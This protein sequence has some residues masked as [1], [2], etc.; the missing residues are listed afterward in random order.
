MRSAELEHCIDKR[1]DGRTGAVLFT[2]AST[3][4][5]RECKFASITLALPRPMLIPTHVV[6]TGLL[7]K[8]GDPTRPNAAM[9]VRG[10][11]VSAN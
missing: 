1:E 11:T 8:V 6:Y 2:K 7:E 5:K 4:K 3:I 10:R 9:C